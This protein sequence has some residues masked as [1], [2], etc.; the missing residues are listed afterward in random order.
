[1][2]GAELAGE[3]IVEEETADEEL[4]V[5]IGLFCPS[6]RYY[7][8]PPA[9]LLKPD[10]ARRVGPGTAAAK[11]LGQKQAARPDRS[12]R[13]HLRPARPHPKAVSS[14]AR[15][16]RLAPPPRQSSG[17]EYGRCGSSRVG[18]RSDI[19]QLFLIYP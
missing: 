17:P 3:E 2:A 18:I 11:T 16:R 14:G 6:Q 13:Y 9:I 1:L 4:V 10:R 19:L 15:L 5:S 7:G 8:K 12:L